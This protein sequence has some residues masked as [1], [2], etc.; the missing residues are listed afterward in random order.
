MRNGGTFLARDGEE[1]HDGSDEVANSAGEDEEASSPVE[2][3]FCCCGV[4][5]VGLGEPMCEF[6]YMDSWMTPVTR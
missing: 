5:D 1:V 3:L 6:Q 2:L 4:V